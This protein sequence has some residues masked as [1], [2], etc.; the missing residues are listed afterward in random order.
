[1]LIFAVEVEDLQ[2]A[3]AGLLKDFAAALL[4]AAGACTEFGKALFE[5]GGDGAFPFAPRFFGGARLL[6]EDAVFLYA[7]LMEFIAKR[8]V[9]D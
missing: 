7:K 2:A 6:L 3:L 8:E 1:L 4:I 5:T 9:A